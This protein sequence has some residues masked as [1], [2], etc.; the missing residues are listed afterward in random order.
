MK[1][2]CAIL[3]AGSASVAA[4]APIEPKPGP[5]PT[6]VIR[7]L[8]KRSAIIP[9]KHA[10]SLVHE[11]KIDVTTPE[12]NTLEVRISGAVASHC[13]LGCQSVGIQ[14][15]QLAQELAIVNP[16]GVQDPVP[17]VLKGTLKG[18]LRSCHTGRAGLR[19][20]EARLTS[21]ENGRPLVVLSFPTACVAGKGGEKGLDIEKSG[22]DVV[23]LPPGR[24]VL[25]V[26]FTIDA[27]AGGFVN[28][29]GVADFSPTDLPDSWKQDHD[30]FKDADRKAFG[31]VVTLQ[32]KPASSGA[33]RKVPE[34]LP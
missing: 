27:S 18:Y 29:R 31:L 16:D 32:A 22:P 33:S 34:S 19:V 4:V 1:P 2:I 6:P 23:T 15:F 10:D 20:A 17:L 8:E 14:T 13:W 28:S 11:G 9:G 12:P 5:V 25:A 3:L 21:S 26:E 7:L 24:Y 30:P